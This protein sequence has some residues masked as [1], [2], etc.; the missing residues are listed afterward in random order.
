MKPIASGRSARGRAGVLGHDVRRLRLGAVNQL[1]QRLGRCR[2]FGGE[3]HDIDQRRTQIVA[4]DI[5]ETL[6]L[7]IRQC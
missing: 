3:A 6:N 4:D 1:G 7:F 2:Q 5:G